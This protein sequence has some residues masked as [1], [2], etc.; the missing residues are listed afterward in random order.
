[1]TFPMHQKADARN[2]KCK[3]RI[4]MLSCCLLKTKGHNKFVLLRHY[5]GLTMELSNQF[6]FS[7][8]V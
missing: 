8:M 3:V 4:I 1:M 2:L 7:V 5:Q 6:E